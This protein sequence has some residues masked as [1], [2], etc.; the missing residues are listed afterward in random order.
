[1]EEEVD[2]S[3]EIIGD[4]SNIDDSTSATDEIKKIPL[5][6]GEELSHKETYPIMATEKSKFIVII[7][8]AE[9]GKTTLITSLYQQFLKKEISKKYHFAGSQTLMAFEDRAYLTRIQSQQAQPD[10][11]HT[12]RGSLDKILHLRI[13]NLNMQT[14]ENLLFTDVSGEDYESVIGNTDAAKEDFPTVYS[15]HC[16]VLL[17]DGKKFLNERYQDSVIQKSIN[18]LK[19]FQNANLLNE[20]SKIIVT[21][22]KYDL[23]A[24][25]NNEDLILAV[26]NVLDKFFKQL[27]EIKNNL[28]WHRIAAM[29][30]RDDKNYIGYGLDTLFELLL[31]QQDKPECEKKTHTMESQ[32]NLWEM[33]S[34]K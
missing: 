15:A 10:M 2:L 17:I 20:K 21:V 32:F 31:S 30:C 12:Q 9:S 13:K 7:G 4:E 5:P 28:Q 22:S 18:I 26:K 33:R 34:K 29:P 6:S 14:F 3:S 27:P 8:A 16:I 25:E 19:T 23:I 24:K 1:M 11:K